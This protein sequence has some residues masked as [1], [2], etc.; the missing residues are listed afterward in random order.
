[1][2]EI[3]SFTPDA[4]MCQGE[5]TL[6]YSVVKKLK[7]KGIRVLAACSR[8]SVIMKPAGNGGFSKIVDFEFVQ[9]REY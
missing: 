2:D 5:F 6:T 8:R 7:E 9:F 1:M 4:V 3:L